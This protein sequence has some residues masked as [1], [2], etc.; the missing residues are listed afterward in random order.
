MIALAIVASVG[1]VLVVRHRLMVVTVRGSSMRPTFRDGDRLLV[2]RNGARSIHAD[3]LIVLAYDGLAG[4]PTRRAQGELMV[5][6]VAAGPGDPVPPG[7]PVP[8]RLVPPGHLLV[9]GDN[10]VASADS[11]RAGYY[12]TTCVV[13]AVVRRF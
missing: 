9:V 2:R 5:K 11:R 7:M 8:D 1:A 4:S 6:R 10:A 12:A 3:A 13:G